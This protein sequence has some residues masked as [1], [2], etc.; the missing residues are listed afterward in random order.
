[1]IILSLYECNHIT[2]GVVFFFDEMMKISV[3][4][5]EVCFVFSHTKDTVLPDSCISLVVSRGTKKYESSGTG[6]IESNPGQRRGANLSLE[7]KFAALQD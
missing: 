3:F 4:L 7:N 2:F 6:D 5:I 1:M